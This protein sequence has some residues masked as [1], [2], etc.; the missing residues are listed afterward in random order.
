MISAYVDADQTDWESQSTPILQQYKIINHLGEITVL[1]DEVEKIE[2]NV[3]IVAKK[4]L[5]NL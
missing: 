5:F 4:L 1:E 3:P 2:Q